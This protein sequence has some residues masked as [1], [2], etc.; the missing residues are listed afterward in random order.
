VV[1]HHLQHHPF[2]RHVNGRDI[3]VGCSCLYIPRKSQAQY[4]RR[5]TETRDM[6]GDPEGDLPGKSWEGVWWKKLGRNDDSG[7]CIRRESY[8]WL[9][10]RRVPGRRG[11]AF[12]CGA[13]R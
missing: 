6:G 10:Q 8:A 12:V 5:H 13:G 3:A 9:M 7:G 2:E 11:I 4:S 1:E